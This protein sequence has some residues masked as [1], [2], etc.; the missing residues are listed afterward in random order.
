M[1]RGTGDERDGEAAASCACCGGPLTTQGRCQHPAESGCA[2]TGY[3]PSPA[4]EL[5]EIEV[6]TWN[7]MRALAKAFVAK[8]GGSLTISRAELEAA[9][10]KTCHCEHADD[11]WQLTLSDEPAPETVIYLDRQ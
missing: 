9:D 7:L 5:V 4:H 3:S 1:G 11:V 2:L 8:E 10:D 6:K